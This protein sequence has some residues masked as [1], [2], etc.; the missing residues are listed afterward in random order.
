LSEWTLAAEHV[1]FSPISNKEAKMRFFHVA[2]LVSFLVAGAS[3]GIGG[4]DRAGGAAS[5]PAL[6]YTLVEWPTPATSAAGFPA[7]WNFIQ[8]SSVAVTAKGTVLVL[9]RGAHPLLEFEPS[10][11][12]I[13]SWNIEIDD[14]K[15]AGIPQSNWAP[16]RS[17]YSAVYGPAGCT[18]CGAHSVRVDPQGNIWVVDA[19][20]HVIYKLNQDGKEMMRLGTKGTSGTSSSTFN[21]PTD[22]AFGPNGDLY[23]TDGYGGARVVKFTRE[24]KY[25]SQWGTR[26]TGPGQFGLPH[27][28]VVDPQGRVYVTDRDNQRIQVFDADGKFLTEWKGTGGISG[29][30]MTRD[31]RMVTGGV[32]RDLNGTLIGRLPDAQGAHGAAVDSAGNIYLAQLSGI[33]QKFV[34]Q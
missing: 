20:A 32:L 33:V 2:L 8:V 26:G 13:R 5:A 7:P 28:V 17:H 18:D 9:H 21:L 30:A 14:G 23:V 19:T 4:Q 15:V 29:L 1:N 25:I 3:D 12:L 31:G 34:K 22:I 16:D 11:K 10:G 24:G 6:P 27:N